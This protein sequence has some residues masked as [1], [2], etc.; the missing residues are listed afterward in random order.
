MRKFIKIVNCLF[1]VFIICA[2]SNSFAEER[3]SPLEEKHTSYIYP[4]KIEIKY[5]GNLIYG[6]PGKNS[7][8]YFKERLKQPRSYLLKDKQKLMSLNATHSKD[9]ILENYKGFRGGYYKYLMRPDSGNEGYEN[10]E[11]DGP[12]D[13]GYIIIDKDGFIW[14]FLKNG[15]A[16]WLLYSDI[17]LINRSGK[18]SRNFSLPTYDQNGQIVPEP[19]IGQYDLDGGQTFEAKDPYFAHGVI[20]YL[21]D[22]DFEIT[23]VEENVDFNPKDFKE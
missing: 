15:P 9:Q 10:W 4:I 3:Y 12:L 14:P 6:I 11:M 18:V 8:N 23:G 7:N 21:E 1:M 19:P 22:R 5:W 2:C 17:S 13:C 20:G 16:E